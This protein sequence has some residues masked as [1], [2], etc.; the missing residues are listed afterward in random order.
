MTAIEHACLA[1]HYQALVAVSTNHRQR[2]FRRQRFDY[3]TAE[4]NRL[5]AACGKTNNHERSLS[6]R[7]VNHLS[8]CAGVEPPAK[9]T[10]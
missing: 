6:I 8:R 7:P 3:H 9:Q 10:N 2:H 5:A 1:D 4:C